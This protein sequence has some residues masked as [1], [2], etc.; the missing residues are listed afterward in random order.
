MNG[1]IHDYS[2]NCDT[3][4]KTLF[5]EKRTF[6]VKGWDFKSR[7]WK[8]CNAGPVVVNKIDFCIKVITSSCSCIL[9]AN[10]RVLTSS[11]RRLFYHTPSNLLMWMPL[12]QI[13]HPNTIAIVQPTLEASK[14]PKH[15][16]MYCD[17]RIYW[18]SII[19]IRQLN[20]QE[21]YTFSVDD[22]YNCAI[23]DVMQ[24]KP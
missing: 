10:S 7:S 23:S 8:I 5:E 16:G 11:L 9:P 21:I 22:V 12:I 13:K 3:D 4:L 2:R 18:E 6:K 1:F 24:Y 17:S 20:K 15:P 19:N 14:D